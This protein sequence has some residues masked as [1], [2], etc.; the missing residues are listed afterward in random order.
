MSK[1]VLF[2]LDETLFDRTQTLR[3]FLATQ[4]LRFTHALGDVDCETWVERFTRMD[5]RGAKSK[6]DLYPEIL[7]L[8]NGRTAIAD[9]LIRDYYERS[10][11]QAIAIPGM[12]ALL[13]EFEAQQVPV[14]IVT[15]GE[16]DLQTRT[17]EALGLKGRIPVILIS[18]SFG[19]KKPAPAIFQSAARRLGAEPAACVFVG[20]NAEADILGA[21]KAGMQ[22]AWFN[23]AGSFWP[24][25]LRPNPG[26]ELR[27]LADLLPL[28]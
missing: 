17:L 11:R 9:D 28:I 13:S 26:A 21:F 5:A 1:C 2:D 7:E 25:D 3:Q 4:F 12:T 20:D 14:G 8:Y 10:T 24:A 6:R 19:Q 18:E 16:T 27:H 15:N 23:P 22:T